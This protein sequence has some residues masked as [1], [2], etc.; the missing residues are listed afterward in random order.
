M[1]A[2]RD[3]S[4]AGK[5]YVSFM[6]RLPRSLDEKIKEIARRK[7]LSKAALIRMILIEYVEKQGQRG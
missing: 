4:G 5:D 2:L 6:V 3:E 1:A 7:G